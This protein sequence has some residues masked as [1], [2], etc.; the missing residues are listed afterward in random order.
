VN[1]LL[2]KEIEGEGRRS[3]TKH[4]RMA[5]WQRQRRGVWEVVQ[6]QY[7]IRGAN[8]IT[9]GAHRRQ[10]LRFQKSRVLVGCRTENVLNSGGSGSPH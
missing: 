3:Q 5:G 4:N 8:A 2:Y 7:G 6:K 9:R 10:L 1:I